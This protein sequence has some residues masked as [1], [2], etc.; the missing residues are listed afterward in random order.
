MRAFLALDLSAETRA[1][2]G[3]VQ[4][5]LKTETV[6]VKWV[7]PDQMHLTLRFF[8]DLQ[9]EQQS[10][11]QRA[12]TEVA[13]RSAVFTY[14]VRGVGFFASGDRLKVLWCGVD[15][16]AGRLAA[17]QKTVEQSL[18]PLK[19]ARE[20][21]PFRAHL[22]LGRLKD[23]TR[24]PQLVQALKAMT[25]LEAGV[26]RPDRIRL[27]QSTLMPEGPIYRVLAEW[28]FGAGA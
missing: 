19:L 14:K 17:L 27:Y 4:A 24:E 22:T 16:P 10:N 7:D 1:K 3:Q 18:A 12:M 2:L 26:E 8:V 9:P 13:R 21:R 5:A 20:E 23:P 28:R 11:L 6:H 15:D 25:N